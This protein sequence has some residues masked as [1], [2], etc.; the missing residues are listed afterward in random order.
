MNSSF[1]TSRPGQVSK[2]AVCNFKRILCVSRTVQEM[3]TANTDRA[4][5]KLKYIIQIYT[6]TASDLNSNS[7]SN[8]SAHVLLH[9]LNELRKGDKM[10]GSPRIASL[11]RNE[12]NK[13]NN[14]RA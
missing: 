8:M 2:L 12:L 13:F 6:C 11:F 7:G 9:F 4:V 5:K 10:R 14:T 1:I 3:T